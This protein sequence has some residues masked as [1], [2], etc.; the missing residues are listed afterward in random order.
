MMLTVY[1]TGR[2][3]VITVVVAFKEMQQRVVE[4]SSHF[5]LRQRDGEGGS[6]FDGFV[7]DEGY[8]TKFRSYFYAAQGELTEYLAAYLAPA[9]DELELIETGKVGD[10]DWVV[11]LCMP[12]AFNDALAK[13]VGLKIEDFVENYILYRWLETKQQEAAAVYMAAADKLKREINADLN[14]RSGGIERPGGY[15]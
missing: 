13:P 4:E 9:S 3:T 11:Q 14:K 5:A 10:E 1:R 8:E 6:L 12:R 7:L 15:W 2:G